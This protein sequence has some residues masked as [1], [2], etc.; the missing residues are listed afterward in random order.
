MQ[1]TELSQTDPSRRGIHGAGT[2]ETN[3]KDDRFRPIS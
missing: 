3:E 1:Y 2:P